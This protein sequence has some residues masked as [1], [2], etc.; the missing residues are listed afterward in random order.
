M[1]QCLKKTF[2]M[3]MNNRQKHALFM[4][5]T[6]FLKENIFKSQA[7]VVY[8]LQYLIQKKYYFSKLLL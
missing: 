6:G 8:E 1:L 2:K 7:A 3:I 4:V 5:R